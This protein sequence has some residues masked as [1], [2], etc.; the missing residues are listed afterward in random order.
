MFA[1]M[2]VIGDRDRMVCI[3]MRA[4]WVAG[5]NEDVVWWWCPAMVG[6]GG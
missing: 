6:V 5:M 2:L 3:G 1:C 4:G